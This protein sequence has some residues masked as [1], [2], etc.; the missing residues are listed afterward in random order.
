[1]PNDKLLVTHLERFREPFLDDLGCTI[2][3]ADAEQGVCEMTFDIGQRYCH[4]GDVVQGGFVSAMLDAACSH[5]AFVANKDVVG[6]STLEFKTTF[7]EA[8]RRGLLTA[9]GRVDKLGRN[10][11]F[12]S[13]ELRN[14][15]GTLTATMTATAKLKLNKSN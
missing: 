12:M 13:G 4:S 7:L 6:V 8:S 2:Q 1:M 14:S 11:A 15:D 9:V 3:R 10:I 5:A